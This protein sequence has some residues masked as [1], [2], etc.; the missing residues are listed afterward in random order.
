MKIVFLIKRTNY[1]RYYLSL[2]Q[3]SLN[4]GYEV[5]CWHDYL[6]PKK[7]IKSYGFPDI[8][9]APTFS[10]FENTPNYRSYFGEK[11]L[12]GLLQRDI[13]INVVVSIHR[14]LTHFEKYFS[15]P[16]NLWWATILN[17]PDSFFELALLSSSE[18]H[19]FKNEIFY[20]YSSKW[21]ELGTRFINRYYP[22]KKWILKHSTVRVETI[23]NPEFDAFQKISTDVVRKK[24]CIPDNKQLLLYLPFPYNNRSRSAYEKAFCGY[25]TNT[26]I[27]KD[28]AYCH[29]RRNSL[30]MDLVNK[31]RYIYSI[32]KDPIAINYF[33]KRINEIN[34]FRTL[35]EFCKKNNLYLVAKPR[36]KFPIPE[37]IKSEA[38]LVIWDDENLQ[39]PP[40]LKELL[41]ISRLCVSYYSYSTFSAV[42]AGVYHL[43]IAI[44]DVFFPN[45]ASKFWFSE[46]K[47]SIFNYPG[48]STCW[49]G[50]EV[51]QNLENTPIQYFSLIPEKR[52]E[53]L[54]E[55]NKI[56]NYGSSK[57]FFESLNNIMGNTNETV[58]KLE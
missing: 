43:N 34:V 57:I 3:E 48:C 14:I 32:L 27:S 52:K 9:L 8:N 55:Y 10:G 58:C 6:Y 13:G 46:K 1:Y 30:P 23:G 2:I 18:S 7:G 45:D 22:E 12:L 20:I 25:F 19:A 4:L 53:Y 29:D 16:P 54:E 42:F 33:L 41:S 28:G 56:T 50:E 47:G 38:D 49:K 5:E 17:G 24:Y 26:L 44:P 36:V 37:A 51:I 11:E 35:R 40:M 21:I 39:N 31:L 15:F